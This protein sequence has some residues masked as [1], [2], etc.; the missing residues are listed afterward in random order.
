[1][2]LNSKRMYKLLGLRDYGEYP[3]VYSEPNQIDIEFYREKY[4]MVR[5]NLGYFIIPKGT[6]FFKFEKVP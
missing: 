2:K 5:C 3:K 6:C 4:G 1:M